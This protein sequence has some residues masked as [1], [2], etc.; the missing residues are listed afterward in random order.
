MTKTVQLDDRVVEIKKLPLRRYGELLLALDKLPGYLDQFLT[1]G[2]DVFKVVP[3]LLG[4]C[5]DDVTHVLT[6]ATDMTPEEIGNL[7]VREAVDLFIAIN[8]VNEYSAVFDK[9]KKAIAHQLPARTE[10]TPTS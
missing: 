6:V 10:A 7:G 2:D 4:S 5:I 8:E 3:K 1:S 9:I